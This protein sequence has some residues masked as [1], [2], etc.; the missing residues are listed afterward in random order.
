[1]FSLPD[2]VYLFKKISAV[3]GLQSCS[4][5]SCNSTGKKKI[6]FA[7]LACQMAKML[8]VLKKSKMYV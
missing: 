2:A 7:R 1:M 4:D 5:E 6:T 3:S 8:V